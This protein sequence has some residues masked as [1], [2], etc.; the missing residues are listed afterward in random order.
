[1]VTFLTFAIFGNFSKTTEN[2]LKTYLKPTT[3]SSIPSCYFFK[4]SL[5]SF[6]HRIFQLKL[7]HCNPGWKSGAHKWARVVEKK[8]N[9][10]KE[11]PGPRL[12]Y[13]RAGQTAWPNLVPWPATFPV[14]RF[15]SSLL[16]L[17]SILCCEWEQGFATRRGE[18][19]EKEMT[20]TR[21][22]WGCVTLAYLLLVYTDCKVK[23]GSDLRGCMTY[24]D[25][26]WRKKVS[27]KIAQLYNN[28]LAHCVNNIV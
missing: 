13:S 17:L 4:A 23:I 19:R 27:V 15:S 5:F 12:L 3:A 18:R 7:Q 9:A 21:E 20:G 10:K 22:C 8:K 1:M 6:L 16:P 14:C 25:K 24:L 2:D 28:W 11:V 26:S